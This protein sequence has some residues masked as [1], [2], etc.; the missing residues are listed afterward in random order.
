MKDIPQETII[1]I[2][3]ALDS[4]NFSE[5]LKSIKRLVDFWIRYIL[6]VNGAVETDAIIE[7]AKN[8]KTSFEDLVDTI[9]HIEVLKAD[10]DIFPFVTNLKNGCYFENNV[11]QLLD[12]YSSFLTAVSVAVIH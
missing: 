11:K 12:D 4:F 1:N 9:S 3:K 2:T 6:I 10:K 5:K 8:A 7:L